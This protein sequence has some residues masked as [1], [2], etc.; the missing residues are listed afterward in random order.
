MC[1]IRSINAHINRIHEHALCFVYNDN[2]TS[3]DELLVKSG[4]VKIEHRNLQLLARD[5]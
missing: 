3:F 5:L 1:H 4:S 2:N